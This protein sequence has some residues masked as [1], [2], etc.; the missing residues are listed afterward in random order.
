MIVDGVISNMG[1]LVRP[2][3]QLGADLPVEGVIFLDEPVVGCCGND[4][5]K[6]VTDPCKGDLFLDE[7]PRAVFYF[8]AFL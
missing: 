7:D 3:G 2:H 6:I 8:L 5:D 1:D 4:L